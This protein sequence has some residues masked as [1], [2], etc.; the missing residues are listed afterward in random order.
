MTAEPSLRRL[1]RWV[2]LVFALSVLLV[3]LLGIISMLALRASV[4][5]DRRAFAEASEIIEFGRIR[6][7]LERKMKALDIEKYSAMQKG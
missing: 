4:A 1:G 6:T 2:S 5:S 7:V 3:L